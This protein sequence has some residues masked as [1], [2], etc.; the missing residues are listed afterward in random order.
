MEKRRQLEEKVDGNERTE[1]SEK[2]VER[3]ERGNWQ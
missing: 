3:G 2:E 1:R